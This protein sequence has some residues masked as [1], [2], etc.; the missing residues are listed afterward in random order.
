MDNLTHTA[1]G[2]FL[3]RAG[4]N[5]LTPQATAIVILAANAPDIDVLGAIGGPVGYLEYHRGITHS[6]IA[7]PVVAIAC[8]ALVALISRKRVNWVGAFI[9]ALIAVLSHLLL[10]Y[11]NGYGIRFLLPFSPAYYRLEWLNVVDLWI[12]AV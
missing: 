12:W 4:L 5:R 1:I 7:M 2:L 11:T 6:F 9:A 10:D 8:V 3:S